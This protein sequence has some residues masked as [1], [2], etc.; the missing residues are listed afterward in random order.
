[1]CIDSLPYN[2]AWHV[3]LI[4]RILWFVSLPAMCFPHEHVLTS[5]FVLVQSTQL[6]VLGTAVY[7]VCVQ[8][9][10]ELSHVLGFWKGFLCSDI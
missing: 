10:Y 8:L 1:M 2:A 6:E 3:N 5:T 7:C 9:A 4:I